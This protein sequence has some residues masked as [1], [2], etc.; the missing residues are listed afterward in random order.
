L[1]ALI[2]HWRVLATGLANRGEPNHF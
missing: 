2:S 1:L